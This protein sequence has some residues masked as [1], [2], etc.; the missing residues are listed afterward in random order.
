LVKNGAGALTL[1]GANSFAGGLTVG[2]GSVVAG[3]ASAFGSGMLTVNAGAADLNGQSMTLAGLKGAGGEVKLGD[4]TVGA[5]TLTLNQA[6]ATSYAG[7]ISG[8]G[9]LVKNGAGALTLSGANSFAGGLTVGGGSVVAGSGSAFGSGMLTVNAGTADFNGQS[10]TLAGLK[11]AGGEVKLG[12]NTVGASVL[13]LDQT[14]DTDYAGNVTGSGSL[15]KGGTGKLTLSGTNSFT[16]GV[17]LNNGDLI[18]GSGSAFGSGM[19]TVNA[20]TADLNGH[21]LTLA[22]LQGAGGAVKL[23]DATVG[24]STLTLDQTATTTAHAIISGTG[25]ITMNGSG[26]LTLAGANTFTGPLTVAAG[27]VK[28]GGTAAF[29]KGILTVNGGTADLNGNSLTLTGLQ[30]TG[31]T[32]ALGA[33]TLTLDQTATT[34][35]AGRI[36]GS[37]GLV[38]DG[39][40]QLTLSGSNLF[41]GGLTVLKGTVKAGSAT[42]FSDGLLTVDGGIADLD[43]HSMTLAGLASTAGTPGGEVK[44]GGATLTLA[45]GTGASNAFAG[46]ITGNGGLTLNGAGKQV[47]TGASTYAGPTRVEKGTLQVNGSITSA[48][49]V[50]GADSVLSGSGTVTGAVSIINGGTLYSYDDN[51]DGQNRLTIKGKLTVD[52]ASAMDYYYGRSPN[53]DTD[54]LMVD[55]TGDVD[56]NGTVNVTADPGVTFGPGI[57]GL[58]HYTGSRSGTLKTGALPAGLTLQTAIAGRIN[59]VNLSGTARDFW[60][61]KGTAGDNAI[62]G[63]DGTWDADTGG[64][65]WAT[66]DGGTNGYYEN[67]FAVFAGD[68]G[69]VTVDDSKGQIA[70]SGM[71]FTVDGYTIKG[72]AITLDNASGIGN[73]TPGE[74]SIVV[75][76][77]SG[78][79]PSHVVTIASVLQGTDRLVKEDVGTLV[80]SGINLYS[81]G[82]TIDAGTLQIA[83]D[84][85]LGALGADLT[86]DG[87]PSQVATLRNIAAIDTTRPVILGGTGGTFET[88]ADLTLGGTVSGP[89]TLTKTGAA[90]L[91][92]KGSN[93]Y[94]GGTVI[95]AGTVSVAADGNLGAAGSGITFNGGALRNTAAFTTSARTVTVDAGGG[96]FNTDDDLTL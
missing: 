87:G 6:A 11:G 4:N 68:S 21:S 1:S 94:A 48:T 61:P 41:S 70:V 62:Q 90:T 25:G 26:Q 7:V 45:P 51:A 81:G 42:A 39:T 35:Y 13:T 27:T 69:T 53:N 15:K 52:A 36:T 93:G 83:D 78:S 67:T 71:Q 14:A 92:L 5:S 8:A 96:T 66:E 17:T 2:G 23:G 9:A 22:G 30:G 57:Y 32:V 10:M 79:N 73:T 77:R 47:L 64:A 44:L 74:T 49:T 40:G 76:D 19:L 86:F 88:A 46:S 24:A 38:M 85:N 54:V 84:R 58:V 34:T 59:L 89:G 60:D 29:G 31:G 50:T 72:D 95:N 55:V 12:D 82:T 3:S 63:G 33:E 56:L 20:G 18:A 65:S 28:A 91:T 43:G 75:G 16:G 80:L 37:G